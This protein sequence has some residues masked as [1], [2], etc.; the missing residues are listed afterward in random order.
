MPA[1]GSA[2]FDR[3]AA[4][5]VQPPAHRM[6]AGGRTKE[7]TSPP[8]STNGCNQIASHR[9][10]FG[11]IDHAIHCKRARLKA[12]WRV[13]PVRT[14]RDAPQQRRAIHRRRA[15][16]MGIDA[17]IAQSPDTPPR[18][19]PY[20]AR[21]PRGDTTRQWSFARTQPCLSRYSRSVRAPHFAPIRRPHQARRART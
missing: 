1:Q 15:Q 19:L 12:P 11:R 4:R 7:G 17:C 13:L 3:V 2:A 18:R 5:R 14:A 6:R 8:D 9:C 10:F 21:S 16:H 20:E